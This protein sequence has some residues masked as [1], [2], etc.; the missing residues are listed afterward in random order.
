MTCLRH[1]MGIEVGFFI[2]FDGYW[3]DLHQVAGQ[4]LNDLFAWAEGT[5]CFLYGVRTIVGH[6][7]DPL[8]RNT[9]GVKAFFWRPT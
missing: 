6:A 4:L 5:H 8:A 3:V 9:V 7:Q 2:P 1:M